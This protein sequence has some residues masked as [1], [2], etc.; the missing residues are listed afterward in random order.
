MLRE[1][2]TVHQTAVRCPQ[3]LS[4]ELT[5]SFMFYKVVIYCISFPKCWAP[6][7]P[8]FATF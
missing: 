6:R 7:L 8:V 3:G 4:S 1:E 5:C 2:A